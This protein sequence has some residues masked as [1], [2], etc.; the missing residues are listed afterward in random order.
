MPE[1]QIYTSLNTVQAGISTTQNSIYSIV[2][3]GDGTVIYYDQWEDGYE[4]D[5]AHPAQASTQ[6][7]GDGNDA[8]GI[9]PGFAHDPASIPAGTVI[10]LTNSVPLPRNPSVLLFDGRD[11]I[12]SSKAIVVT[13][14]GWPATPGPVFGGA[15]SVLST[16]DY[17]TN[18]ISPVGQDLTNKLFQYV[19]MFVMAAQ[20]GT[21]VTIDT[22]G[23][24]TNVATTVTLNR[25]ESYLVNGGVKKGGRATATKPIQA[26]LIIGHVNGS[27]A[28]DW[29]TLVP[30]E[31]WDN[32][33][34]TPVGTSA[35][36][37][38]AY[39][40]LYNANTN[41]LTISYTT[42]V[43][44]G[45]FSIPA[46]NGVYQF[47]MPVSSG[48]KFA[49]TNG[50][51]FFALST[52]GANNASD[53]AYNW[54]FTLLPKGA[55]T[56]EAVVGWG[57]GSADG[58]VNGS[59]AWVT[60]LANTTVYVDYN[61]DRAGPLTDSKGNKYDTNYTVAALESK[62]IFDPDKDQT[63][64]RIYTLDG[65]L[66]TAAWGEDPDTAAPGNPYIDAG[67]TVL[68]FPV[69][70]LT[71]SLVIVTDT[72][73]SGLS[74]NDI[75]EY[76][77]TLDNKGLLPLGNTVVIDA[78]SANLVYVTNTTSLDGTA[79]PDSVSGT[80]FPLDSPG[81]TIPVILRSGSSTFKYRVRVIAG[82]IVSNSVNIAGTSISSQ[83]YLAPAPS[84]GVT[85]CALNFTDAG[86]V[87]QA[88]YAAGGSVYVTLNNSYANTASNTI[89]TMNVV[90]TDATNGDVETITLTETGTNTGVFRNSSALPASASSGLSAQDGVLHVSP[91][92]LLTV[93]YIDPTFFATC[94]S[95]ATIQIPAL[96]KQ[97]Y[98]SANG[99]NGVQA[100]NRVNPVATAGHGTTFSSINIGSGSG[101]S[102]IVTLLSTNTLTNASAS[103]ITISNVTVN[104]AANGML[105]VAV[106]FN[107]GS[108][109]S[110]ITYGGQ[111]LSFVQKRNDG[112]GD[113]GTMA[114]AEIWRLLNPSA[115]TTNVVITLAST[116]TEISAG[117]MVFSG[118][119]QTTPFSVTNTSFGNSA[120]PSITIGS[121]TNEKVFTIVSCR[122]ATT[123]TPTGTGQ[124]NLWG[125]ARN[126]YT[127]ASLTP[128]A[129]S[130]TNSWT[131]T[132]GQ[133]WVAVGVSIKPA[134]GGGGGGGAGTNVASFTQTPNFSSA[135]TILSNS[136]VTI[137]NYIAIT[138]GPLA[139]NPVVTAT[140]QYNGTSFLTLANPA[141]SAASS[142]LVWTGTL[143]TNVTIPAGAAIT[144]V[145]SNGVSGTQF[146]VDYDSTNKPSKISLP[147][148]TV[149]GISSVGVYDAPYPGGS[150]VTTPVVGSPL[151]LRAV[152][153]D[154]FG[155]YD[156]SSVVYSVT[157]PSPSGNFS[158]T[159]TVPVATTTNSAIYEYAWTATSAAGGYNIGVV[160]NE[161]TEGITATA[162][163]S[164]TLI[165]LDLGT[166]ST[167]EFTSGNN[168]TTTNSYAANSSVCVRVTDLDQNLTNSVVESLTAT[169]TSSAGDSELVTLTETGTNTGVF[170]ACLT[171]ST[172]SGTGTNNGVL[173]APVG[174]LLTVSY[175][176][177]NDSSDTSSTTATIVPPPGVP[178][179]AVNKSVISP[180]NGQALVGDT[181]QFNLQIANT[182]STTLTNV[183]LTDTF[184]SGSLTFQSASV[185][186]SSTTASSLTWTNLGSLLV[187][188]TTNIIVSF[189]ATNSAVATNNA[190]VSSGVTAGN[191]SAVVTITQP[192][193]TVTKT[194]LSPTNSP[195][196]ITSN[197]VFRIVVRNTGNTA[198][199][200]LPMEDTFSSAYLQFTNATI[201][202][203]GSGAGSL[204]WTN[205]ASPT[206]LAVGASITN[207]VTMRVVGAGSPALNNATVDFAVDANGKPVPTSSSTVTNLTTAAAKISGTVY[208]DKDQSGTVTTNDVGLAGVTMQLFSDPN[209]DG[210][211][212][213]GA[214]AQIV[215][216]DANGYYEFLNLTVGR[217]VVV[218]N[219]LSGF[220]STAPFG[221]QL[222]VNLASLTTSTNNNFFDYQPSPTLYSTISGTVWYDLNGNG[223]NNVGEVGLTNVS[224]DLIQDVNS[225][226][227]VDL[228]EP[229]VSS[230]TTATNGA[231]TF[232]AITP[233]RYIIR[234][235]DLFGYYGSGDSQ[236]PNNSQISV[237]VSGG[238]TFTNNDF[239]SR[240]SPTAVNDTN[241][242]PRNVATVL[243]PL[244]N[245]LSPNGDALTIT[246]AVTSN[247]V[248]VINPGSTNLTYTAA[249]LGTGIITY[250]IS[251][252]HGGSSTA[253]ITVT[254][255]NLAPVAN[256][257]SATTPV[258]VP[259]TIFATTNDTDAN[260]DALTITL[261]NPTNGTAN[262]VNGT[263]V[264]FTP[265][266][267]F[268]GTG[269]V[270]YTISDGNGGTSSA[271]ITITVTAVADIAVSK[272]GPTNVFA[273]TN[274]SY[275]ITVTNLGAST[276][277]S[278]SVTDALPAGVAF[279]SATG[280]G[281]TNG[282]SVLWTNLGNLAS[283]S[284]TNLTLTVTA[285][286]NGASLTNLA[287][288]GSP[289]SDPNP[290]NNTSAPVI[291][292][293][294]PIANLAIGKTGPAT[295]VLPGANFNYTI[296]VT[297]FG[298]S[299]ASSVSV[300]DSL[301]VNVTFVS[302]TAG[303]VTS[304]GNVIWTNLGNFATG[305]TTNLTLTVTAPVRGS[306]TNTASVG[307]PTLDPNPTNNVTPPVTTTVSNLPPTLVNDTASTPKNIPVT[308]PVLANDSDTNG[309]TIT[310]I[311]VT[312]TNGLASV[313]G[314]NVVF[315]P[316]TNF[317]GTVI[318][319]YTAIDGQ[320][321]TNTALITISVTNRP[322]TAVNDSANGTNRIAQIISPLGNDSDPDGD[323]L[324]I[325]NATTASG[326]VV[327][328]PGS[329]NLTFT[330]TNVGPATISY[331]ISDGFGGSSTA[332]ITVSV[333]NLPPVAVNDTA[334]T[335]KNVSVTVPVLVNDTD[336]NSDPLTLIGVVTTNGVANV[337][338]T[339]VVYTPSTNFLG[340]AVL[341]Y[342]II[343]GQGGT[344]S[345]LIT[346]SVTNRPP[347]AVDDSVL[348]TN[349]IAQIIS[350]LGND[351][352]PDGDALVITNATT[353]S[354]IVVIN[355]GSTN[356]TFTPTNVGPATIS[357]TISDGFGGSSTAIITVSVTNL[358][359]VAVNDS[360][361]TPVNVPV[362]IFATTNDTDANGDALTITLVNPTNGTASIVNGTN[363]LFTPTTNFSGT[364]TV[365]YTISDGN[366]GT[367]SALI[368]INV[369]AVAD[370]AVSKTGPT[371][372]L[373]G[374]N[375]TYTITV[376]NLGASTA[377]SLSV[378]DALPAS[379]TFVSATGGGVTNGSSVLWTNL[380]NL[381]ANTST[382]LVVTVTAPAAATSLTNFASG[383]SPTSDPN[384]T[385]NTSAPVITS[386]TPVADVII[387]KSGPATSVLP[388]ANFNYTITVSNV[389]PSI[390]SSV[391]V[392]DSLPANVTFVSASP[393]ATVNGSVLTWTNLG[394]FAAG[395]TTTLTVTVTAPLSGSVTNV[396]SG[397]S[398][399]LDPNPTN[400]VTPPVTTTV[401]NLPPVAVNDTASTPK[402]ISVTVPV[403][404]NDSDPNGDPLTLI[405]VVTTNG[406]ANVIGTN[407]VYTPSTNFIGTA[408]LT[409]TIIDGQGG[410]NSAFITVSVTNRPPTAVNDSVSGTNNIAQ[411]ISPLGNDSD[412]DGD[413]LIITN[414]TTASGIV[415][416][417]AGSTNLTFTPTNVG[418]ATISYTI[419]DGF[420]GS[421]T[422]TITV[423]VTNLPPTLVDDS[424]A[425][426]KNIPVTIPV[427]ANDTDPNGDPL[428]LIGVTQTN[429]VASVSGTNVV[430][431]PA[432][433]FVG[434]VVLTYTVIDGQGG[435]NSALI[436]IS[437]TNR[438][439]TA[440]ND[441][442]STSKNVPVT[443]APLGNDTDPDNDA[444]T[445][446]SVSPTNG[447]ASIV[448]GTN[449]LFTPAT[450]FLGAATVGYTITDGFGGTNFALIT[451]T[452]T[453]R[454]PVA[455]NDATN[456]VL[457]TA[458]TI[459]A[460]AN[461]TDPD[462]DAL[463][464]ISVSATNGTATFT[465]TTVT[466]TPAT[467]SLATGT[468]AYTII[469]G[470]GGTNSALITV[471]VTNR[472][473]VALNDTN[474]TPKN[475]AVTIAPLGNDS[476]PDND[477]LTVISVTPTNGIANI[478]GGTNVLFTPATN[479]L[480]T[481]TVGYTI[482]DGNGGT[483]SAVIFIS[484]TNRP[485]VAVNDT[486]GTPRNVPVTISPRANDTDPDGD[487]LTISNV[488]PTN[489]VA[490][491]IG[492][493]NVLFTPTTNFEGT[494][495]IGYT[496]I[497][498]FG[499]TNSALI[500]VSVTN[501]PPVA[502]NDTVTTIPNFTV[503]I[504][505]RANDSD[506]DGDPLTVVSVTTTNGV[507]SIVG[508]TNVLFT[509]S[510]NFTGTVT[511]GY[512]ITDGH[513]GTNSA[514]II[515]TVSTAPQADVVVLLTG[516]TSNITQG[517][518]INYTNTVI[519][520]GPS[521]ATNVVLTDL[522]L[523]TNVTFV[524]AS[525]GGVYSNATHTVT[526]PKVTTL[527][528]GAATNYTLVVTIA[529]PIG[530]SVTITNIA[531]AVSTTFDPNTNNNT[532][533]LPASQWNVVVDPAVLS[534]F[535]ATP[536]FNPQTG[537]FQQSVTVTNSGG[538]SVAGLRVTVLGLPANVF[539]HNATGTN[540][541]R[542]F[543][544]YNVPLNPGASVTFLMEFLS[545]ARTNFTDS[546]LVEAV[547]PTPTP[548]TNGTSVVITRVFA[549]TYGGGQPSTV[550]EFTSIPGRVYTII[551]SDISPS[552][553]WKVATPTVTANANSYQWI[554]DGPPKTEIRPT[555]R[556]YQVILAP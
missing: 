335:P 68:P 316:A 114:R 412:P 285:P 448:G 145:I 252:G 198:I 102:G 235:T 202:P 38:P 396:A 8:N 318:L 164:V 220:A 404:G 309:D 203:N 187:G 462:G 502:V 1:Q 399:T 25:G 200:T 375:F 236:P 333:T 88:S 292:S 167:S 293:V 429:G 237:I 185:T 233:D 476:D 23:P 239:Y 326:T 248:V 434:S 244:P 36:G 374:N 81:Y 508:G 142:N 445:V 532:G 438:P 393:T 66:I 21:V 523:P 178:G 343:D 485:P 228:G 258:N 312:Q 443:I 107:P 48:A 266:T 538:T 491:I 76:T 380:G 26:D 497:D 155:N 547:L 534:G 156:I 82:G 182:G 34:Y 50:Q 115:G 314:T 324:V 471:S 71:K 16:I 372:V 175:V 92:D 234:K 245:D 442:A 176:D 216:T 544:Q 481:A 332:T 100:L 447:I 540:A 154:P 365:G 477:A 357:Y 56:T 475:V 368:T 408:V 509:P 441:T 530:A 451:V 250:T 289:T 354:G 117:A 30:V 515:V 347:T 528:N 517:N 58:T 32:T 105:L 428:T 384:P 542:P 331:T 180:A 495:T 282:S 549:E 514:S 390:A 325:T 320:G 213:D 43:G 423:S 183:A 450:N 370:I 406:V 431:A 222:A 251:D 392:T 472:P 492:G 444:L 210:N 126:P 546:F 241:S 53:T 461:D 407:V 553:P 433:N 511:L 84:G 143:S 243:S 480:G 140:L 545:V 263:N 44:S 139:T 28:A 378:T 455:N 361:T 435:T 356:L 364:A 493:T 199:P 278:L 5:L 291:T 277:N 446:I 112:A 110:G 414:A 242:A 61:G 127:A 402:N 283:G 261:V 169:V 188:Q 340:T 458:V 436:T 556:Y 401:S 430:F 131:A 122:S 132:S 328:N 101:G 95:S 272:T 529:N 403:L 522:L 264:L 201:A 280:G 103:S 322:P 288:G 525:S 327:I 135:F 7:W 129:T 548:G 339:N 346:V 469:D 362:T 260:G 487:P 394:D 179:I 301:P 348:G 73:P 300:T 218:E 349:N 221:N 17:G 54:G 19:G 186:P 46:T 267:N 146:H 460:L 419:S 72:I 211:P 184:P 425:T 486:V 275:T 172:N 554:D 310:L 385:N 284:A 306:V 247:G 74:T 18:Y 336:P 24:G 97:L 22:D 424:A 531:S 78:P 273:G 9:P 303:G 290:T 550:L 67:T 87:P 130:V 467:N 240:L 496:I 170:T 254:V 294:T 411:I 3:T 158:V 463:T 533:V 165:V 383:G 33:Y 499:G 468:V 488:S 478:I 246:N 345:A 503:T 249:S 159:N 60:P 144:Y 516:P 440:N 426:T 519:N 52:V 337:S 168:G 413:T 152:V 181:V 307:G 308:I 427:L 75:L 86:G 381:A 206:P 387:T 359:P 465:A 232:A 79:I 256:N 421:S 265:T 41:A 257:D 104:G 57:P 501:R 302:A 194:L 541:G 474:A 299:I 217:W 269:T 400:N 118:V 238:L 193:L 55:L 137:T 295:S 479:F 298:P 69:P 29:F 13:H 98:L 83:T 150:L 405:G 367:A 317:I 386:V 527:A 15:V 304:G 205:L 229:I 90:V 539:L 47:T 329:T 286:A 418:P 94:S 500:T 192:A 163:T 398:P 512:T 459:N 439:P 395:A 510:T 420:G 473:P 371:N 334:S 274:F 37:N 323:A 191:G 355:A 171:T 20:D 255:T 417:N 351:S 2:V 526:W 120:A 389:G 350:P 89:Q 437:V 253:T 59:P 77:V 93:S 189:N 14:A 415:V 513:G 352:D 177:P 270:G 214:L 226:G 449:V 551:Y 225:N 166:P 315:A 279:V 464:I 123:M 133:Q 482:T 268:N 51:D 432:T 99:T 452:V 470:F 212:A 363:V 262:I 494:A 111:A 196:S 138:N 63:A 128:G 219:H 373:A 524:S 119:D 504:N 113:A 35:S 124:T 543:V 521:P 369:S 106:G 353:A 31:S 537:L 134:V 416:I 40:Y 376:T 195:V 62:K 259:V 338:G 197:V 422:A 388:G 341:T 409:Y 379:V 151:Y 204:L 173:R 520:F 342:T 70:T 552:G 498:G 162:G 65:T 11:R 271:L 149:I 330:P 344:N 276:A 311:S 174:S 64:M 208:N 125:F 319:T 313:S 454:A 507:A 490:S 147:T 4:T 136:L 160:A 190:T 85:N 6:I 231:Y 141:Y 377:N 49:S 80:A 230:A 108:S 121:V 10:T 227:V 484:V 456:T 153:T 321:G 39:V 391:T 96:T 397:G 483:N 382:D 42:K 224:L 555:S 209:G 281:V 305:A 535:G 506:P 457:N 296:S 410:T 297:N 215:T 109:V 287:A 453:N 223:T 207:D 518:A 91:G 116:A 505:P 466:F 489:G 536:V 358:P 27:Y 360:A 157:A 148:A 161:G 45:S 12:D 366:G